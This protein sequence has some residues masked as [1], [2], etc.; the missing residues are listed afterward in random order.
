MNLPRIASAFGSLV[1]GLTLTTAP[2]VASDSPKGIRPVGPDGQPL[3]LGFEDGTLKDW[4]AQGN[5]FEQ[6]PVKGDT[7]APRRADMKSQHAGEYWV[8]GFEKVGD[9]ATGTL[10]STPFKVTHR[11]ASFLVGGGKWPKTC[12]ELVRADNKDVFFRISGYE[13]ENLRPVV[14]DL[15]KQVGQTIFIRL[16]DGQKGHWGHLNFDEFLFHDSKPVFA[17]VLAPPPP[18]PPVDV[19][20]FAGLPPEQAAKEFTMPEGFVATVFAHEPDVIQPVA[21]T[22][23]ERGRLWVVQSVDYPRRQPE[24]QGKDSIVIFEDSDNDGKADKRTVFMEGLNLASAIEVGFGG[25]WVGSAPHFLFIPDKDRDDK[26]DGPPQVL[27]DGWGY[28]D[29][30]ETLNTFTWGPDGWL[31]GCHGVFTHSNVGKPGAP[32][33]ER[34]KINAGIWR[35]HPTKHIFEVF[36]EGTSNPWGIDFDA[37]GQ[38]WAEACVIPHL[39]HIIQGARYQR[40]AGQHFNPYTFDDIKQVGD[41]VHYAG[42]AGPHAGNNRSDSAGGGHAHAGLMV[43]QGDNWPEQYRGKIFIGNIHGQRVNMDVPE[44]RGSG[45]VGKHGPDFLNF[46]DKWSQ[47]VNFRSGPDGGVYFIDW[48]DNQQCHS[49]DPK[50]HDR[51][52]GRIY[53]VTFGKAAAKP[54]DL[55]KLSNEELANLQTHKNDWMARTARR[56]LQERKGGNGE[57]RLRI[58]GIQQLLTARDVDPKLTLRAMWTMHVTGTFFD[59]ISLELLKSNE[60]YVAGWAIQLLTENLGSSGNGWS[61]RVLPEFA[62]LAKESKSP[63]VRRYLAS[64]CTRL[65]LEQRWDI[66]E[67]LLAHAEDANDH[68]LPLLYWYAFE[69]LAGIDQKRALSMAVASKIP[70]IRTFTVRRIAAAGKDRVPTQ[71]PKAGPAAKAEA[72]AAQAVAGNEQ[73]APQPVPATPENAKTFFNGKDLT[74][75]W[76]GDPSVWTVEDGAIVGRTKTGL[77]KND[78]LKNRLLVGDFR[79]VLKAKLVPNR[80]NSGIQFRSQPIPG[81]HEMKG[82]QADMGQGWWGKLYHESGRGLLWDKNP[83]EGTVKAED[84]NTYEI[85]AVGNKI[86]TAINGRLCVDLDDTKGEREGIIAVQVHSGGPMEVQFKDFE[87]EVNPK[88]EMKTVKAE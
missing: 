55:S 86:R 33:S 78:F 32:D 77:K 30:H 31:Y 6:Q 17:N 12:V 75:W 64:A 19:V 42:E 58:G 52:N 18:P 61:S 47:V 79:L 83:P 68:N 20:K 85:L 71:A 62:R 22:I 35:Y 49:N 13:G 8:G 80:E 66:M 50:A 39:W 67:G 40:Q 23:D 48:Y 70:T 5:A 41:H 56:I 74:G 14:V 53:K 16:V 84:W 29:T 24:G 28:Q 26:P 10:T 37:N 25:V 73:K 21:F 51:S 57:E 2:L 72:A 65:P 60:P 88:W 9:D 45:Y 46:N 59:D 43:Y 69:P 27:L 11:W 76:G 38:L 34:T 36:A 1:L 44:A 4:T 3:N 63:V 82:Y 7:V 87:L 81:S 15:E 54:G